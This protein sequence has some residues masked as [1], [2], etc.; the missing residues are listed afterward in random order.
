MSDDQLEF[1]ISQYADGTLPLSQRPALE[2]RLAADPQLAKLLDEYRALDTAISALPSAPPIAFDRLAER[3]SS[4]IDQHES[5]KSR[6]Y[7]VPWRISSFAQV[8]G[9]AVAACLAIA[10]VGISLDRSGT[11]APTSPA[12]TP[13]PSELAVA[14]PTVEH[15]DAA[16]VQQISIGPGP[17][18][19]MDD[20]TF[21]YSDLSVVAQPQRVVIASSDPSAQDN[22]AAPF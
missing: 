6:I 13:A 11:K 18:V 7:R 15:S 10:V 20:A 19:A 3:I 2:A 8:A 4:S 12:A 1:A 5:Q 21:R 16:Q 17:S 22:P 14:G 9:Y